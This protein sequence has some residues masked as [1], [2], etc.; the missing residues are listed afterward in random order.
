MKTYLNTIVNNSGYKS[1]QGFMRVYKKAE[2]EV[3]A[4]QKAMEQYRTRGGQK[5]P[6]EESIREQLRRLAEEAKRNEISRKTT[7]KKE[8]GAR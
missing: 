6:E 7:F 1:V 8:K 2:E 5:P 3:L 4:Y